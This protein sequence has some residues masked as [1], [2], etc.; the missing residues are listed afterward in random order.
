MQTEA[1]TLTGMLNS[2]AGALGREVCAAEAMSALERIHTSDRITGFAHWAETASIAAGLMEGCGLADVEMIEVPADGRTRFE[3]WI[4]PLAW[5]VDEA[6][7]E[8]VDDSGRATETL[9]DAADDVTPLS[10][11]EEA[12]L[13][14]MASDKTTIFSA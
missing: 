13:H 14:E 9:C 10:D 4:M 7:L 12:R 8:L 6:R 2:L 1:A 5:D 11:E 3:D